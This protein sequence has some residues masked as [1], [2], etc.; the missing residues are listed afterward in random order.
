[1]MNAEVLAFVL[2][3]VLMLAIAVFFYKKYSR[4]DRARKTH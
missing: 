4:Q 3:I 2:Y 1:M